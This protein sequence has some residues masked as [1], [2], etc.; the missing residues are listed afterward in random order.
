M[1]NLLP[2]KQEVLLRTIND[3]HNLNI[4]S[5]VLSAAGITHR[6]QHI[7]SAHLEIYVSSELK[8]I[9]AMELAAYER[10][11]TNWPPKNQ[12]DTYMPSFRAMSPI[13]AG[14][15]LFI[16]GQTG[17]WKQGSLWFVHGAGNSEAI[18]NQSQYYRLVTALTL[19]A[20]LVHV[21][22][23]CILGGFL[24]HFLLSITGNGI[25]I[26]ML[27]ATGAAANYINVLAHGPGHNF[28]G[29]S[30]SIFSVIGMLCTIN[31]RGKKKKTVLHFLMPVMA[32]LALLAFLGSSGERTDLGG[33]FF[34]LATGLLA[35]N[36]VR[37]RVF[38]TIRNSFLWQFL[39]GCCSCIVVY[40]CWQIAFLQ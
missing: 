36:I 28:V 1:E 40:I 20:D 25:G 30:T 9:A 13:I 39:L 6:I 3:P 32:G 35:G 19:H 11:N 23:N 34:G 17:D 7:D 14:S 31:F 18:L 5:L 26:F 2:E 10:E 38:E 33:H 29:F 24:V 16:Y 21:L 15:L 12:I 27:L 37:W 8:D 4:Y 22:S